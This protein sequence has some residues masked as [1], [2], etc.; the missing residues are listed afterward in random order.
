MAENVFIF[1]AGASADCGAPVMSNFLQ[2]AEDIVESGSLKNDAIRE[3]E[4]VFALRNDLRRIYANSDLDL[5]NIEILF[6]ITEMARILN[7]LGNHSPDEINNLNRALKRLII[8]TLEKSIKFPYKDRSIRPPSTYDKFVKKML[9]NDYG[10]IKTNTSV[11]TFNYDLALDYALNYHGVS[12][13]YGFSKR[14]DAVTLLKLHGSIN[15]VKSKNS[16]Q[17]NILELDNHLRNAQ[18]N[19]LGNITEVELRISQD[20]NKHFSTD[21]NEDIPFIV[22]PTWNKSEYNTL[23]TNVWNRAALEISKA[24]NIYIIGYSFPKSDS[25]FKYLYALGTIDNDKIRR[26]WVVNP[27][28]QVEI[29]NRYEEILG[30]HIKG[31]Y[32]YINSSFSEFIGKL[33]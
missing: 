12:I 33:E 30:S 3:L 27:D 5:D 17:I 4:K 32:Q 22:P 16:G 19:F 7:I 28:S 14:N 26:L 1:G 10:S 24:R 20:L 18:K 13:D 2:I 23:V 25:F 15:W 29:S 6:G 11:I 31:K 8:E 21:E 9:V